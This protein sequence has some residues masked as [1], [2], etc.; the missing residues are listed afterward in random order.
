[1]ISRVWMCVEPPLILR[2]LA[3]PLRPTTILLV[4]MLA[5][6]ASLMHRSALSRV[7][8][9][10]GG[11]LS[12]F[13]MGA[14]LAFGIAASALAL[15]G[16]NPTAVLRHAPLGWALLGP[17]ALLVAYRVAGAGRAFAWRPLLVRSV[18]KQKG[19]IMRL[20]QL[21]AL[22]L[23]SFFVLALYA[24]PLTHNSRSSLIELVYDLFE[25]SV[26]DQ[27]IQIASDECLTAR[28][29]EYGVHDEWQ[30][31][32]WA[33]RELEKRGSSAIEGVSNA[34]QQVHDRWPPEPNTV[35]GG[36]IEWG[37]TFLRKHGAESQ[38]RAWDDISWDDDLAK[39]N[40]PRPGAHSWR[41]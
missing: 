23:L 39:L 33:V 14:V 7:L 30:A 9:R 2:L 32:R 5:L 15:T 13:L 8:W 1:M 35:K 22:G 31:G 16:V 19:R 40:T 3:T 28:A 24:R 12:I 11:E 25:F 18:A 6:I 36:A 38:A 34:M 10:V 4:L 20:V 29:I 27:V 37:V 41:Y 26:P 21:A 17:L